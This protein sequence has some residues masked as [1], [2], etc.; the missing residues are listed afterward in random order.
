M[1]NKD[2]NNKVTLSGVITKEPEFNHEC[3]GVKLYELTISSKRLSGTTDDVVV[4]IPEGFMDLKL[5][6]G[7][8]IRVDGQL[9]S[10][11]LNEEGKN[12]LILRVFATRITVDYEQHENEIYLNGFVCKTPKTR[13]TPF[14][15]F[16]ADVL[17]A[18]NRNYNKSDYIPCIAWGAA[19]DYIGNLNVGDKIELT[20]RLQSRVYKKLL[21]NG[22]TEEKVA[23]E[24]SIKNI[25]GFAE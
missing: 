3:L 6:K 4:V 5:E 2:N 22:V 9:R 18:V 16:I 14:K 17:V 11:N 20:G 10:H 13:V 8:V 25:K 23:Y 24:V 1:D 7:S 12:K 21:D 19:A 15:R